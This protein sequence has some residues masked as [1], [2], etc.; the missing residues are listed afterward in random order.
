MECSTVKQ[1]MTICEDCDET[2]CDACFAKQAAYWADYFGL[3]PDMT[4]AQRREQLQR[5]KPVMA[6]DNEAATGD[7]E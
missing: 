3:R 5:M 2:Y 1:L 7:D 6:A 4:S